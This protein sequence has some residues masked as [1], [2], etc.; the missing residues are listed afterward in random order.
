MT[1]LFLIVQASKDDAYLAELHAHDVVL[2][3]ES[4]ADN[5]HD[6]VS[7]VR[8]KKKIKYRYNGQF[9]WQ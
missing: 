8:G 4:I 7:T 6:T 2:D 3:A 9:Q 5:L 1:N